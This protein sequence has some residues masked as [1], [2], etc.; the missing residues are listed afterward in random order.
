MTVTSPDTE[1]ADAAGIASAAVL[2]VGGPAW[3]VFERNRADD[4]FG[5]S[6]VRSDETLTNLDANDPVSA[7]AIREHFESPTSFTPRPTPRSAARSDTLAARVPLRSG[8]KTW[9][10]RWCT[11]TGRWCRRRP[12]PGRPT[13]PCH[14]KSAAEG[15]V[16]RR[17]AC[18]LAAALRAG[19]RSDVAI[20]RSRSSHEGEGTMSLSTRHAVVTGGGSGVGQAI[21]LDGGEL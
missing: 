16:A 8:G 18:V 15:G 19:S 5:W 10:L 7:A 11:T 12:L 1:V 20:G 17:P 2:A 9:T 21:A 4:T 6:V 13:T 14:V 3:A